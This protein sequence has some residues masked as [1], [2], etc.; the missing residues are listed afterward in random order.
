[1]T[2]TFRIYVD[3]GGNMP[4]LCYKKWNS[5]THPFYIKYQGNRPVRIHGPV[6]VLA[7]D[8]TG[9]KVYSYADHKFVNIADIPQE[10][11]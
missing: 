8:V 6:E 10:Q 11:L 3:R 7:Q 2:D 9:T 5:D 1:M 4:Q